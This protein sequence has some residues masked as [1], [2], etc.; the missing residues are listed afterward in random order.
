VGYTGGTSAAA[1]LVAGLIALL[2][3][4][5]LKARKPTMG[6]INPWLYAGGWKGLTDITGGAAQ[7]CAGTDLQSG[8]PVPGAGQIP[9]ATWNATEGTSRSIPRN[10]SREQGNIF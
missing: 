1:P 6:F 9:W 8:L 3:D 2:N 5:R 4:A 10:H 7:G